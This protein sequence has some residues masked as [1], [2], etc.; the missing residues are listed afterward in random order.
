MAD[1][2]FSLLE[3]F[4]AG[5]ETHPA[6]ATD[7]SPDVYDPRRATGVEKAGTDTT[8]YGVFVAQGETTGGSKKAIRR[9]PARNAIVHAARMEKA[10]ANRRAAVADYESGQ[11][12]GAVARAYGVN[13]RTIIDWAA[14]FRPADTP[15][16]RPDKSRTVK[17]VIDYTEA[18]IGTGL[19]QGAGGSMSDA[20]V[21]S[22]TRQLEQLLVKA[23]AA[24]GLAPMSYCGETA[25]K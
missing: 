24:R 2:K 25:V 7:Q 13:P 22:A 14:R 21:R 6:I 5:V 20:Q 9:Y 17:A 18:N 12:L 1:P 10:D 8:D 11:W 4:I 16:R 15:P 19:A 23:L 3:S